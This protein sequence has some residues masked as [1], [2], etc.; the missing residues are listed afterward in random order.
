MNKK[1]KAII[2]AVFAL[3]AILM[4]WLLFGQRIGRDLFGSYWEMLQSNINLIPL[5]TIR[6]FI[7]T[8][9][10]SDYGY[11]LRHAIINLAGNVVMFVPLGFFIPSV[12]SKNSSF[13]RSMIICA[14]IVVSIE[15]VQLFTLLGSCDID[16]LI[17]NLIGVAIGYG[18]YLIILKEARK[19][20]KAGKNS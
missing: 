10:S 5:Q 1:S 9:S 13:F 15:V 2:K 11:A 6:I 8:L 7:N 14:S 17:L 3:Y 20:G 16:D 19:N 18:I 12:F 4:L